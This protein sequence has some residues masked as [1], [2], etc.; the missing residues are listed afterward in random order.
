MK[1]IT[2]VLIVMVAF[3]MSA[4]LI[5]AQD[6][7][8]ASI[9]KKK[10][11]KTKQEQVKDKSKLKSSD[12]KAKTGKGKKGNYQPGIVGP[13]VKEAKYKN[14]ESFETNQEFKTCLDGQKKKA[15]WYQKKYGFGKSYDKWLQGQSLSSLEKKRILSQASKCV[16]S[17]SKKTDIPQ[18]NKGKKAQPKGKGK[19]EKG[20]KKG[21]VG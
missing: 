10:P 16:K 20:G 6:K 14:G 1:L 3:F 12:V 21:K 17:G 2:R 4:S 7:G 19:T 5:V 8:Q 9:D 11:K 13:M 15:N 18:P